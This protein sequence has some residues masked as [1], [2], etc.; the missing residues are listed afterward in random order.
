MSEVLQVS[1]MVLS[2]MPIGENDKR[3]VLLT[4]ELGRISAFARGAR[5]PGS[6]LMAA[7]DPPAF[8]TFSLIQ[9]RNSYS[10]VQA[11]V[12]QYFRELAREE[13]G[14]Y[15]AYYFLDFADYYSREGIEAADTLNLLYL[16][17][18]ALLHDRLDNRLVRRIFEL[19]LMTINGEY[20][21]QTEDLSEGALYTV[22]YI[23]MSPME[24]LYTFAVTPEILHEL[25]RMLD[26]HMER[27]LDRPLRSRKILDAM[28]DSGE[29]ENK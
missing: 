23:Q 24:K 6:S 7:S 12:K 26:R 25:G 28:I 9:G 14:I 18:K 20:A 17:M 21:V 2:S 15:Y 11:S 16:S 29:G 13:T 22:Q 1:G 8:G 5:R 19:R 4:N 27:V 10:L 3:I